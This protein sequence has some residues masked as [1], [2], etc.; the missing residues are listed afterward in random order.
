MNRFIIKNKNIES[1]DK[2]FV[3]SIEKRLQI[4]SEAF[5]LI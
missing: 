4:N 3:S 1:K 5:E 2:V